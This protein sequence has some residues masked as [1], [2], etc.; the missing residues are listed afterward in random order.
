MNDREF[1]TTMNISKLQAWLAF[2]NVMHNVL[3]NHKYP[4]YENIVVILLDKY[5]KLR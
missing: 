1:K 5:Q 2:K 3:G 4:N